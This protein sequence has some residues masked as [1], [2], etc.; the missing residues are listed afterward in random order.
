MSKG[1]EKRFFS[2]KSGEEIRANISVLCL[3]PSDTHYARDVLRLKSGDT[4]TL[5]SRICGSTFRCSVNAISDQEI[6]LSL[7]GEASPVSPFSPQT[8][9]LAFALCKGK[10]TTLLIEKATELGVEHLVLWQADHSV[11]ILNNKKEREKKLAR[12]ESTAEAAARQSQQRYLPQLHICANLEEM[13]ELSDT[14]WLDGEPRFCCSLRSDA[15]PIQKI[16]PLQARSHVIVG[17]EGDLSPREQLEI[18]KRGFELVSLGPNTLR[19]ETAA[20][21]VLAMLEALRELPDE[22]PRL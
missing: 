16:S 12:F 18:E 7:D 10:R 21:A 3:E 1:Q 5:V 11:V 14:L 22:M 15:T 17:P 4:I 2:P 8:K 19:S 9:L 6:S 13:L 20:I